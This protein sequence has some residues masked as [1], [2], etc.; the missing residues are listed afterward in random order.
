M[1]KAGVDF[2]GEK[3][4]IASPDRSCREAGGRLHRSLGQA[5]FSS[6]T[7]SGAEARRAIYHLDSRDLPRTATDRRCLYACCVQVDAIVRHK[8]VFRR[9]GR[10][11]GRIEGRA[12]ACIPVGSHHANADVP[13]T[14]GLT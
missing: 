8:S 9:S 12:G 1:Q 5:L 14:M 2:V 6:Y 3:T 10:P 4:A 11:R 13:V 7:M